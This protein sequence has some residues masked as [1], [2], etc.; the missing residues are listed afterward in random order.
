[1][2][3][4]LSTGVSLHSHTSRSRET[5]C[6]IPRYVDK[7]PYLSW[8]I[9]AL[10]AKY[11]NHHGRHF[12]YTRVWWMPPLQPKAAFDLER[13]QIESLGLDAV[14]SLSDHDN[15]DA[16]FALRMF[17]DC[18][19]SPISSE[20]T[21][22]I[23]NSFLH[24]G[25]HN[26]QPGRARML[27]DAMQQVTA[28]PEYSYVD[29]MLDEL[30]R[31]PGTL[32]VLNHPLWDEN[33]IGVDSHLRMLDAFLE[34]HGRNIHALELNGL[35][36]MAENLR[37]QKLALQT[38]RP[39]VTGGDRHG[40]EPNALLNLTRAKSFS[41]FAAEIREGA[42]TQSLFMPQ[43]EE[44]LKLRLLQVTSDVLRT[45]ED[46]DLDRRRW[47]DRIF[48]DDEDGTVRRISDVWK[49]NGPDLIGQF[50]SLMRLVEFRQ[51][52]AVLRLALESS[53]CG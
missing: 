22:P 24:I 29:A 19:G 16:G 48:F 2:P 50:V 6:F 8:R 31:D 4:D 25:V 38:G 11:L 39:L 12:D 21:I 47:S 34:R 23:Q 33:R 43:Y 15:V 27:Q 44:P 18:T 13:K 9:R 46:F 41:E 7:V 35:R 40:C 17:S 26:M 10:E 32:I 20:W 53:R 45:Y 36:S 49:G 5:M 3:S 14:V 37:V 28:R 1:M 42:P 51:V 30:S 52:R